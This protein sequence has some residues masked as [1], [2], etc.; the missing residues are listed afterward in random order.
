MWPFSLFWPPYPQVQPRDVHGDIFDYIIVGG[1]F[2]ITLR[3]RA[4]I[5]RTILQLQ[6]VQRVAYWHPD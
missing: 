1:K 4:V 5:D 2:D 6:E 3:E